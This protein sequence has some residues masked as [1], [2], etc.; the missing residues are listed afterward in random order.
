MN[1]LVTL[2]GN[3]SRPQTRR[4]MH[5]AQAFRH[6][7]ATLACP[8]EAHKYPFHDFIDDPNKNN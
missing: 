7:L 1:G 2:C 3:A 6:S 8:Y 5:I 4:C